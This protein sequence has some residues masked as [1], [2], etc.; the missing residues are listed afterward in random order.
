MNNDDLLKTMLGMSVFLQI[1]QIRKHGG[2]TPEDMKRAQ[3]TSD[4][5]GEHGDILLYGGGKPGE[6]ADQFNRTAHAI[7]VLAFAPGGVTLFGQ[8]FDA[9]EQLKHLNKK[10]S[11][12][13]GTK[14][15]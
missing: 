6:C 10:G 4:I 12:H 11:D 2:P 1:E 3:E 8:T 14:E 9:A 13:E 5:L 7:A 15:S